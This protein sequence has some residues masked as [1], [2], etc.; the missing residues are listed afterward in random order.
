MMA[1]LFTEPRSHS[2]YLQLPA[3]SMAVSSCNNKAAPETLF[4]KGGKKDYSGLGK[5]PLVTIQIRGY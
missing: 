5:W 3:E 1:L 4:R 2:N